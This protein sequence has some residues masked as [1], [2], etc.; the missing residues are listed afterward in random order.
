MTASQVLVFTRGGRRFAVDLTQVRRV[1]PARA[2]QQVPAAAP[3]VEGMIESGG[4][5][6]TLVA[7]GLPSPRPEKGSWPRWLLVKA[8]AAFGFLV[9]E[10]VGVRQAGE[11]A[12]EDIPEEASPLPGWEAVVT[13]PVSVDGAAAWIVDVEALLRAHVERG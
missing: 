7:T 13:R 9:D 3:G 4:E 2:S 11:L 12:E 6:H 1:I 5:V 10:V 8:S